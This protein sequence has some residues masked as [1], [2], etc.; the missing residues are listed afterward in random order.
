MKHVLNL[1]ADKLKFRYIITFVLLGLVSVHSSSVWSQTDATETSA[2]EQASQS[3]EF[4]YVR[5]DVMMP[6]R[7]GVKLHAQVWRPKDQSTALP[8]IMSRSPYGYSEERVKSMLSADGALDELAEDQF[9]FVFQDIRGRFKSEGK[10][11]TLRPKK[12]TEDGIDESTDTYDS[13]DWL[14]KNVAENNGNVGV[15]GVSYGGW[16]AALATI[17][18]HPALKAVSSQASPEDMFIGDDFAHNGAFR[19]DYAWSWASLLE[20]KDGAMTPFDFGTEDAYSW[21]LEQKNLA[22]LDEQ[23]LGHSIP[24]WQK[25]V[26]HP[27]YDKYWKQ[28]RTSQMMSPTVKVPNLIVA[29]WY[30]QEDFYGPL[31]IYKNQEKGDVNNLN[32]LVVGPWNHGGWR[33]DGAEYGPF[34][35]N[36]KTGDWFQ[37]SVELPWFQYWLK[38]EGELDQP[39]ALIFQTGENNWKKLANW[40]SEKNTVDKNLYLQSGGRLSFEEPEQT[41]ASRDVYISDPAHP[42]PYRAR[43]DIL[44]FLAKNST[45]SEWLADDQAEFAG[46]ND[47]LVW[48]TDPLAE[49]VVISGDVSAK[50]FASTSGTDADWV[51]KLIDIYPEDE[52]TPEDLRG[53]NRMIANDVFRGRYRS[54]YETPEPVTANATLEYN[55]DLHQASHVFKKGHRIAVQIQS[56]WFPLISRNPQTYVENI[57]AAKPEDFKPQIHSV[58]HS[59]SYPSAISV[60]VRSESEKPD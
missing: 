58:F 1:Y 7:D 19:L 28:S 44:P 59:T 10:Y 4:M 53:Y 36:Q 8:M 16:T 45:W 50:L 33:G 17:E 11:I 55:I 30:D 54:S 21:Y 25:F 42:V 9:I 23:N 49:D 34:E 32:Y 27:D 3:S 26:D 18:P 56:S 14:V 5:R 6:M 20:S 43:E 15:M 29:G 46:R 60:T 41:G 22:T 12:T 2:V 35:F 40:P 48:K 39:E 47:V 24:T 52:N 57:L 31:E 37:K 38:G 13:I 51:V